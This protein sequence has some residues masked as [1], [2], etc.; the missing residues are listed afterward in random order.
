MNK[1]ETEIFTLKKSEELPSRV[2]YWYALMQETRKRLLRVVEK[3]KEEELDYSPNEDS[4]ET[5]GTLLFHIAAVE[6]SW[7]FG[8]IDGEEMNFEEFKHAFPLRS[9]VNISQLKGKGKQF[10]LDKL[11]EVRN[12][13]H[14]R[15]FNLRDEELI[16]L[17]GSD[18][19][20][21]SIEWILFHIIEHEAMHIGQIQL[22]RRLY[23]KRS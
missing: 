9:E 6:W 23:S 8:D 1:K 5:I 4:F 21:Y 22:L 2:S 11:E 19:K 3:L 7:I 14:R 18:S 16:R 20:R 15:L 12:Q 10:Y 13:V 17:V